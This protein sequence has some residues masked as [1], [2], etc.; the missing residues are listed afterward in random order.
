M[1]SFETSPLTN[2]DH[3]PSTT[4]VL[5]GGRGER[6]GEA[7]K[8]KQK[9][10]TKLG[11]VALLEQVV[12]GIVKDNDHRGVVLLTGHASDSVIE[13]VRSWP[14]ALSERVVDISRWQR[15]EDSLEE[16]VAGF[17]APQTVVSGNILLDY[18]TTLAQVE[19]MLT[20]DPTRPVV[21]GSSIL[22]SHTQYGIELDESGTEVTDMTRRTGNVVDQEVVDV[23]GITHE[24]A[25]RA[26]EISR[27]FPTAIARS[28]PELHPRFLRYEGDWAHF[29][30][31]ED[32]EKY[33]AGEYGQ[34]DYR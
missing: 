20:E 15:G 7:Y 22:R 30:S 25:R 23:Y 11:D 32:F 31:P 2:R 3:T 24:V 34:F 29:E 19:D 26:D 1:R 13:E 4:L 18:P 10:L 33:Q 8:D 27:G 28:I 9:V 17:P 5:A 16:L 21:V 12:R 6:M 14:Q